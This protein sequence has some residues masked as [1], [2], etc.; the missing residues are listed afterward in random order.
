MTAS[1]EAVAAAVAA[2]AGARAAIDRAEMALYGRLEAPSN[3]SPEPGQDGAGPA[4]T[5]AEHRRR[6]RPGYPARLD[7]DPELAAF[8]RHRLDTMTFEGIA[9]AVAAAFPPGRRVGRSAIH[10]WHGRHHRR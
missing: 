9:D 1:D 5:P 4:A 2:L 10:A 3:A 6:H 8:V 7:V